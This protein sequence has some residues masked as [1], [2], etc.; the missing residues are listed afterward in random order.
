MYIV[1]FLREVSAESAI[2]SMDSTNLAIIFAPNVFRSDMI[3]PMKAVMEMRLSK[4]IVRELI[5]RRY[6][7]QQAMHLN[8][9]KRLSGRSNLTHDTAGAKDDGI[10]GSSSDYDYKTSSNTELIDDEYAD[11]KFIFENPIRDE[12]QDL[13][14][15]D[16]SGKL[17]AEDVREITDGFGPKLMS[18]LN[19]DLGSGRGS[20]SKSS[21]AMDRNN[22]DDNSNDATESLRTDDVFVDVGND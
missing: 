7:L 2:N 17:N 18:R 9:H 10:K 21:N 19:M 22:G 15:K 3:D 12:S 13:L 5:D 6:I 16:L 8:T 11:C 4:I 14:G 20:R 1:R